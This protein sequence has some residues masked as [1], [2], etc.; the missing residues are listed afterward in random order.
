MESTIAPP[1]NATVSPCTRPFRNRSLPGVAVAL[2]LLLLFAWWAMVDPESGSA[3]T[4]VAGGGGGSGGAGIG[5]GSGG[6]GPGAG[7]QG[8]G[9]G[10]DATQPDD[11]PRGSGDTKENDEGEI[12]SGNDAGQ[13]TR[14]VPR[15]GFTAPEPPPV[16]API[17]QPVAASP[18]GRGKGG[19]PGGSGTSLMGIET[20]A[21]S[22]VFILDYSGSMFSGDPLESRRNPKIDHMLFELKKSVNRL[23]DDHSFYVIFFDDRAQPM[24]GNAMARATQAN[25]TKWFA[26]ADTESVGAQAGG[27]TDPTEAL[28]F[29]LG[30]LKPDAIYLLTDGGFDN[31]RPF[32]VINQLNAQRAV[33]IN[34][35]GFHDRSNEFAMK[36]IA[37]ENHGEYRYV[38]SPS[39]PSGAQPPVGP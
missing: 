33:Q 28:R 22:I 26:W 35:I 2:M 15:I 13:P 1:D 39:A 32:G 11:Q 27:G 19:A 16:T 4:N 30:T 14:A 29:A 23:P 6:G 3:A 38:P 9:T 7:D 20:S 37:R 8:A 18:G 21:N 10:V 25:K 31:N 24:G 5:T 17:T 34:T 36:Q 12:A